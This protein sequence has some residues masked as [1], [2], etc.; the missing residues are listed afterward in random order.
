MGIGLFAGGGVAA[1]SRRGD[2][3]LAIMARTFSSAQV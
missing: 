1:A 3:G 2:L